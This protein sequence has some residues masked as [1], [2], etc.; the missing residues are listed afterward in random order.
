MWTKTNFRH[1]LSL[2]WPALGTGVFVTSESG[3]AGDAGQR[4]K[5]AEKNDQ[6]RPGELV[7]DAGWHLNYKSS[8][9][10]YSPPVLQSCARKTCKINPPRLLYTNVCRLMTEQ[11]NGISL[12]CV[13][14]R[15]CSF[16]YLG[17]ACNAEPLDRPG[18]EWLLRLYGHVCG[19]GSGVGGRGCVTPAGPGVTSHHWILS[20]SCFTLLIQ[21][22]SLSSFL[23]ICCASI[24]C[25]EKTVIPG[26]AATGES[27]I[28]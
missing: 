8:F 17:I 10:N 13:R 19:D 14:S 22:S 18:P 1:I 6:H 12:S 21:H 16:L 20:H 2:F 28:R 7:L 11:I 25:C 23:D 9:K 15:S 5:A 4:R 3:E 24:K 27:Q 26:G